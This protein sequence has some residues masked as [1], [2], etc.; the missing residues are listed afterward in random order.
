M[1]DQD[2][3]CLRWRE[4]VCGDDG[5]RLSPQRRFEISRGR[6]RRR[7]L[8]QID[9]L[10]TMQRERRQQSLDYG[11]CVGSLRYPVSH[12][13]LV[14]G[15]FTFILRSRLR[16]SLE[17]QLYFTVFITQLVLLAS[18]ILTRRSRHW[19]VRT[20]L[21]DDKG[22]VLSTMKIR[23]FGCPG[24]ARMP[25]KTIFDLGTYL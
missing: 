22:C 5:G 18:N 9:N 21:G 15:F 1:A 2:N 16:C 17:S 25:P 8:L 19:F 3:Q 23:P 24:Q 6:K 14:G 12:D 4:V 10:T 7:S 20:K 13:G 11:E